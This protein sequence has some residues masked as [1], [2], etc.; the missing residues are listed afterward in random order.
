MEAYLPSDSE[1]SQLTKAKAMLIGDC[2]KRAGFPQWYAA[3]ELPKAGP[4]T[5]T[6]WRYGIH[7]A[8]LAQR[9]GYKADE[10]EESAY[11]AAVN[12]SAVDGTSP[13][14]PDG[15]ALTVCAGEARTRIGGGPSTYGD[16]AQRLGNEAFIRSKEVKDV[17]AAFQAW[18]SCMKEQGYNYRQPLDASDD[19]RFAG[20]DVTALEIATATAD[21]TCRDR[22]HVAK[23]WWE[24]EVTLQT[25]SLEENAEMLDKAR[26][27]LDASIK[28][29]A[30]VLSGE[31]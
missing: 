18:S 10:A 17:V 25:A 8:E 19:Q 29:V 27:D 5:L 2:M 14:G 26:K 31:K 11:E 22:T 30:A 12:K 9:R 7:D 13:E 23:I 20:R 28:T 21:I 3:P 6:D 16:E 1:R 15:R 24:A 4:K